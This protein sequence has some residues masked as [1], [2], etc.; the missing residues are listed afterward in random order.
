MAAVTRVGDQPAF[1]SAMIRRASRRR[2]ASIVE[3]AMVLPLLVA[4]ICGIID[5]GSVYNDYLSARSGTRDGARQAALGA[6][7]DDSTCALARPSGSEETQRLMC[8]VK[9]RVDLGDTDVRVKVA[10]DPTAGYAKGAPIVVCTQRKVRSLTQ[11][12]SLILSKSTIR[13]KVQMRIESVDADADAATLP[14]EEDP[15]ADR[16]WD[17]CTV[18]PT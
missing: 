2:G 15:P 16:G 17:F 6:F 4:I 9:N 8:L 7:G 12:F 18:T 14:G 10:I 13:T 11:L 3:F 1:L 5:F